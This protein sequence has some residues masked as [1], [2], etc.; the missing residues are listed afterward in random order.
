MNTQLSKYT[1]NASFVA[2]QNV[3]GAYENDETIEEVIS[4]SLTRH[5]TDILQI[6]EDLHEFKKTFTP[7][8]VYEELAEQQLLPKP[9]LRKVF[10]PK[11]ARWQSVPSKYAQRIQVKDKSSFLMDS[12]KNSNKEQEV[13]KQNKHDS[14][15]KTWKK[16]VTPETGKKLVI[17]NCKSSNQ[18][19]DVGNGRAKIRNLLQKKRILYALSLFT[20][21]RCPAIPPRL[22]YKT[23]KYVLPT[24]GATY[25]YETKSPPQEL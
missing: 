4:A 13:T 12:R 18:V 3:N 23:I 15:A 2:N 9:I 10:R 17:I 19:K 25:G 21:F 24:L 8:C 1:N 14:Q 11:Y 5:L 6:K 16:M 22:K 20:Q 7:V